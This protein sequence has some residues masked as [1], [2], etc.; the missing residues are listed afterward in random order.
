[1]LAD[2]RQV[3]MVVPSC[4]LSVSPTVR[5]SRNEGT[6]SV[7]VDI[8]S[9]R[10]YPQLPG[11]LLSECVRLRLDG[12]HN[13]LE[14]VFS[15]L[16]EPGLRESLTLLCWYELVNDLQN[17]DWLYLSGLSEQEVSEW[18]ETRLSQYPLLYSVVDEYVFF[19]CFGFWSDNPQRL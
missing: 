11:I 8:T 2:G 3:T 14:R 12:L 17:N 16:R 13:C 1:M 19:A 4:L 5:A 7:L 10:S 15:R 9:L 6:V 18:V